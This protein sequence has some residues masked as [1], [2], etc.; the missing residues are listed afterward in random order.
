MSHLSFKLFLLR[1][2]HFQLC[3]AQPE[4]PGAASPGTECRAGTDPPGL[5]VCDKPFWGVN[6][7]HPNTGIPSQS[8]WL[9][10]EVPGFT[11]NHSNPGCNGTMVAWLLD[12]REW[13][14]GGDFDCCV[15]QNSTDCTGLLQRNYC[16]FLGI[17]VM[18]T[19]VL[20]YIFIFTCFYYI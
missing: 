14:D 5:C 20:L 3:L 15:L 10:G 6:K 12:F 13:L 9:L 19:K 16:Y 8:I 2:Q 18:D 4:P 17:K 7:I 1:M 11:Q